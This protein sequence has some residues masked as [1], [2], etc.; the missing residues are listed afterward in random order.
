MTVNQ[1]FFSPNMISLAFSSVL[2]IIVILKNFKTAPNQ[3]LSITTFKSSKMRRDTNNM[4][5]IGYSCFFPGTAT[6][7]VAIQFY[8]WNLTGARTPLKMSSV[9]GQD[10]KC[11]MTP[12]V[13]SL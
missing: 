9:S 13:F 6:G 8:R 11:A 10:C 1:L 12:Y 3:T 2:G 4:K 5:Q 7:G